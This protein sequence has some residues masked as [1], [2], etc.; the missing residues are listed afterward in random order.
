MMRPLQQDCDEHFEPVIQRNRGVMMG[1]ILAMACLLGQ[2]GCPAHSRQE[3]MSRVPEPKP[4]G[5]ARRNQRAPTPQQ[6]ARPRPTPT[7]LVY[8]DYFED[9]TLRLDLLH[10]GNSERETYRLAGL[11][12]EGPW[13]GSKRVLLD[14]DRYGL[15]WMTVRDKASGR[16]ICSHGYGSLFSE[17]QTTDEAKVKRLALQESQRIPMPRRP[18]RIEFSSRGKDGGFHPVAAFDFDPGDKAIRSFHRDPAVRVVALHRAGP[19][20]VKLDI[21][22]VP[23]GYR[24]QDEAKMLADARRFAGVFLASEPFSRHRDDINIWL[25]TAF[26]KDRGVSEPRKG[27]LLDTAVGLSFNTFDSPR[28]MMTVKNAA[29]RRIAAHAPYDQL[30]LMANTSRYGGGGIYNL[31]ST[32]P[33][34]NEYSEYVFIHEFGHSFGGLGDEYYSSPVSTN[35]MYP[36]GVEPWEP[37]LTRWMGHHLKWKPTRGVPLPTPPDRK[38]YG[39]VVGLFEG[40]GYTGKGMYRPALDCKMFS[41][42]HRPF[43][44]VCMSAVERRISRYT[45]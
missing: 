27:R 8:A 17:W 7:P 19:P 26:S 44:P 6:S 11:V 32:F 36:L 23:D 45:H 9:A 41:K 3:T 37:N 22:I 12:R 31:Y 5:L 35:E 20:A 13:P 34:D 30:Y 18:V 33:A 28:Y 42:A 14:P 24:R 43:C 29:L 21:L 10:E 40:A 1:G 2:A 25:V 38:K 4:H 39:S 15:H 16:E